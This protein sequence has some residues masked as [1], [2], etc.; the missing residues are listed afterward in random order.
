LKKRG[1]KD[2]TRH[3]R[4]DANDFVKFRLPRSFVKEGVVP[5]LNMEGRH[6]SVSKIMGDWDAMKKVQARNKEKK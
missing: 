3:G 4:V 5:A 6:D 1:A 2:Y